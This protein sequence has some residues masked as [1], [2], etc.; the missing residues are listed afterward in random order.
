MFYV[1]G[2]CTVSSEKVS[3]HIVPCKTDVS[4]LGTSPDSFQQYRRS[5]LCE[6]LMLDMTEKCANC[7]K[8][9]EK[10]KSFVTKQKK[11][12]NVPAK[13]KTPVSKTH[14]SRLKLALQNVRLKCSLLE[15]EL[16]T[17][18]NEIK[19][20]AVGLPSDISCFINNTMDNNPKVSPFMKLLWEQQKPAFSKKIVEKYHP[21]II[22][23]CLSLATKSGSAY[24]EL[25]NSNVL[26][27][28]SRRTLRD[29]RNAI[30]PTVGFSPKVI[31][32]LGSLTKDF[33]NLQRYICSAFDE[34]KIQSNL[35]YNKYSGELIGYIDLG[36]PDINCT[37]FV[38]DDELATHA[39]VYY[40]R[41][42]ASEL[43]FCL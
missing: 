6:V 5:S 4:K 33:R 8:F 21:M 18:R 42:I 30:K 10:H 29:Y 20:K 16:E 2:G 35:K 11:N 24:D 43:K 38:K 7:D 3:N 9:E 34:M 19:T 41:G 25:R 14:P 31:A 28:P 36:D 12:L 26:V 22:R 37:T 15:K 23:F 1:V 13:L 27:L 39:L 40:I 32:E 17:M